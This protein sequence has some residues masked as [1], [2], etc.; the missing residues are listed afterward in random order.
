M[1]KGRHVN[2]GDGWQR[3]GDAGQTGCPTS[4]FFADPGLLR[5]LKKQKE[6]KM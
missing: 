3:R 5:D 1:K 6:T 2:R 4:S